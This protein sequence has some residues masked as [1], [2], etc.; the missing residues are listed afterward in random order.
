MSRGKV[1]I[2]KHDSRVLA[3]NPLGDPTVRDLAIYLPPS[4]AAETSRRYPVLLMLSGYTGTG[5][6]CLHTMPW[7]EP[8]ARRFEKLRAGGRANEAIIVLPD[9]FTRYGGSQYVDSPAVGRYQTYLVDEI[10]P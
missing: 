9:C 7:T 3:A 4:Y 8:L 6:M 5:L 10:V 2:I 1:E